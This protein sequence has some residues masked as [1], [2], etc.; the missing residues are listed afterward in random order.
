MGK[1]LVVVALVLGFSDVALADDSTYDSTYTYT[2][3]TYTYTPSYTYTPHYTYT[4]SYSYSRS[5]GL[6]WWAYGIIGLFSAGIRAAISASKRSSYTPPSTYPEAAPAF[7]SN[8]PVARATYNN[9]SASDAVD[10]TVLRIVIDGRARKFVQDELARINKAGD[11]A[12]EE[13]RATTL[14]E[15]SI[16]LRRLR[17]AWVFGGAVNEQMTHKTNAKQIFDRHAAAARAKVAPVASPAPDEGVILVTLVIAARTELYT[18][19][20]IAD[21]EDLRKALESAGARTANDIVA[22]DII[23]EPG[24]LDERMSTAEL[25]AKYPHPNLIK[26]QGGTENKAFC[27]YCAGPFPTELVSCPHCGAH[28]RAVG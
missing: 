18:V 28:V 7:A 15:V 14:R 19:L 23:W 5:S 27:E 22:L 16:M 3:S 8:L 21:G 10:V 6:P 9:F 1:F 4:P 26:L 17:D 2:P 11:P 13:G 24:T 25:V 12:T 20:K